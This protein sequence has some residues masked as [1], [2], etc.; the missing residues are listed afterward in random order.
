MP[1]RAAQALS[2]RVLL[3]WCLGDDAEPMEGEVWNDHCTLAGL[4][5]V[6]FSKAAS[7]IRASMTD[8][9]RD[10][11]RR[12]LAKERSSNPRGWAVEDAA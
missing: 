12:E 8:A 6:L 5:P 4:D 1:L 3:E 11:R 9:E 7:A 2:E 10:S